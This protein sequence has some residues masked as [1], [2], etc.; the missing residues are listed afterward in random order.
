MPSKQLVSKFKDFNND[1]HLDYLIIGSGIG[2]LTIGN[3]LAAAGKKVAIFEKHYRPGGLTHTFKRK[4][5]LQWDVGV[6]YM[7]NLAEGEGLQKLFDFLFDKKVKWNYMGSVY[8][9]VRIGEKIFNF[10]AGKDAFIEELVSSFPEERQT[11]AS[12]LKIIEKCNK[13][14]QWFFAEKAFNRFFSKYYGW[15]LK[16][17][18]NKYAQK[19]TQE[20]LDEISDNKMLKAVLSAQCG[21]YGLTPGKSSFVAHALIVGHFLNGGYYPEGGSD[22]MAEAAIEKLKKNNGRVYINSGVE[23][24]IVQN[25]RVEGVVINGQKVICKNVISN[26]GIHNT[27]HLLTETN[28]LYH[29]SKLTPSTGHFCLYVGLDGN[30]DELGLPKHNIWSFESPVFDDIF[31][32]STIDSIADKFAYIS[33]PSAKDQDWIKEHPNTSTIQIV[34]MAKYEWIEKYKDEPWMNRSEE[35]NQIKERIA[36]QLIEKVHEMY[37]STRGKVIYQELSTPLSTKKFTSY[38]SGEIYGVAH[39]KE[40]FNSKLLRP[41]TKIKGLYMVG[42]DITVVGV[43]GAM[44]SGLICAC[45]ILKFKVGSVFK[46][47]FK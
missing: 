15:L 8:D 7:G 25:N 37:P 27:N 44:M 33:F 18:F 47:V 12:Y 32:H 22:V 46:Q 1:E 30:A 13:K 34:T 38:Q 23:E 17:G 36:K 9:Q 42:Q 4:D 41:R 14:A 10:K 24:I 43:A 26:V 2:G 45:V 3:W 20:V 29:Q 6:H 19:S 39:D 16:R 31:D 40:R 11:L 21:N 5:G 28:K 35:Y